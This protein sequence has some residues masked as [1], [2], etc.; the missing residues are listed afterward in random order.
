MK[1]NSIVLIIGLMSLAL[2]GVLAM[3]FYFLRDSYRQ[4][5]QLFDESVNAAITAVAGKLE[6]REVVDFAKVQQ[7]RNIEKSKQEQAKQRLL[8]EQLEIQYRIE[9]LKNKQHVVFSNF[10]EQEDQLRAL[11]PNVIE[12]KNSFYET[13]IKR[14]EY[15]KFIKFSVSNELTDDNLVQAFIMLNASKVDDQI[16]GKD[17]STRFVIPLMD[18]LVNQQTKFRVATLPPRENAKLAKTISDLEKRLDILNRKNAWSGFNVYDSVAMLGGKKADY[19]EDIAIGMELAKRPLKDRL[20]VIIVQ[21]LIKEELAQR[22]IKAPFNIEIWSTNNIL[23][24]NILNEAALNNPTNTTKYSTALFKGD[25]GA[26]PGKLTIYFPNKKAII[27]DN[28]GYLLLPMLALL[29]LLV[30]CFAYTL[31]IIFRQKKVSEMKT[32][33]INNMTHEFK[34]PVATIMIA[35]ESL[36][37]PDINADHKRVQKLANII[38]DENVRL[39]NHIERVLDLARLEKET[40]KLDQVEVCINDLVSAVT[41]SMQLRMQNIGGKFSI[42]LA[43][44]KD[45][46]VGDELHFSNVFY[47]LLDNAIKYSKGDLHVNINSKNVGDTIVVTIADNGIGMSRDHLQ[48]IFDQFYR[49]P[50]GNVHN[51]KG[52]GL[53][54]S[55]VQDILRRLN[56]KITVKSEKDKGTTFEVILPIKK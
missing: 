11:Y 23:L 33:F 47:N 37:D 8:A 32:D 52:F 28:M 56:G 21:E 2:I 7:E 35:S 55:Y 17:D 29:F 15:Q 31:I 30:G 34:T 4:K 5:S 25:I 22:D 46:V 14:P 26:A 48:K 13:Y 9:E 51:V 44:T 50:T 41:D 49:I 39:G 53:G 10:K 19:I 45:V 40:L 42:D 1:K 6:R 54:L 20:N 27:A 43:A 36:K 24:N 3:Q 18:P 16:N 38:Y 12:I